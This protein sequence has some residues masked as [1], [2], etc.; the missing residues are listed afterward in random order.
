MNSENQQNAELKEKV[1]M[2]DCFVI[3]MF[4]PKEYGKLIKLGTGRVA[5]Y[6]VLL[7]LLV[8]VIQYAIPVLSAVAAMGGMKEIIM[9]EVPEFSLEN[10][11]FSF[12]EKLE[13]SDEQA[14]IYMIVDTDV[15]EYTKKDVPAHTIE[16]IMVSESN[17]LAYNSLAGL[18][19]MTE[20]T[21]FSDFKDLTMDNVKL[22]D[23][24][25]LIYAGM[26]VIFVFIWLF[27]FAKHMLVALFYSVVILFL[28]K[29]M[30]ADASFGKTYKVAL[31]A[32]SIGAVVMAVTYCINNSLF[33]MAGSIFNI[34]ITVAIMNRAL[35][36]NDREAGQAEQG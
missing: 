26:A 35:I 23:M 31:F 19:G 3:S 29:S 11:K 22:A 32:Q 2:A 17:I 21:R 36:L 1:G 16:A 24:S 8:S 9:N 12:S 7:T 5:F 15:R 14:G 30:M 4:S 20:E 34:F 6:L 13:Q 28:T 18:G 33:I 25:G 27:V 10:G